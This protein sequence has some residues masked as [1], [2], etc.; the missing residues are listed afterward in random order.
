M[1]ADPTGKLCRHFGTYIE[2]EGVALRGSFIVDP[3][4]ILR[5]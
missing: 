5:L 4:G 2:E 1:L 3:D